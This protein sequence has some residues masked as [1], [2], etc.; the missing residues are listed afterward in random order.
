M[1]AVKAHQTGARHLPLWY[2]L[3][4]GLAI[5]GVSTFGSSNEVEL[6]RNLSILPLSQTG[7]LNLSPKV[8]PW[9]QRMLEGLGCDHTFTF[10]HYF[11][12]HTRC[13]SEKRIGNCRDGAKWICAD[14]IPKESNRCVV[15]SFGSSQDTCFEAAL[16]Q[17]YPH[18]DVH[19]FDP[20]TLQR[21]TKF[22]TYHAYGLGGADPSDTRYWSLRTQAPAMCENCPMKTLKEIMKELGHSWIDVLKIDVDGAEW[23]SFEQMF[24]DFD[25]VPATQMQLELTGLDITT[26]REKSLGGGLSG[27]A[28]WWHRITQEEGYKVYNIE[29]N[30][31]TCNYRSK[32]D[33]PSLEY[34]LMKEPVNRYLR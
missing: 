9:Y 20:T 5:Y 7:T 27:I 11:L 1:T 19:I 15:Y 6:S 8:E 23:R 3:L 28:G 10:F 14:H 32:S 4:A 12:P 21:S 31:A 22:W 30:R 17:E 13:L 34:A 18:C 29:A 16:V 24:R 25:S 2:I 26:D 33:A